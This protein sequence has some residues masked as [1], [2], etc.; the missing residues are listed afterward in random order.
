MAGGSSFL[1]SSSAAALLGSSGVAEDA[2]SA[3]AFLDSSGDA[4]DASPAATLLG[5]SGVAE[6]APSAATFLDSSGVAEG[7]FSSTGMAGVSSCLDSSAVTFSLGSSRAVEDL[8][9]STTAASLILDSL[10]VVADLSIEVVV[11]SDATGSDL[12]DCAG[13]ALRVDVGPEIALAVFAF[14]TT[15]ADLFFP[16]DSSS[17]VISLAGADSFFC[18]DFFSSFA[19]SSAEDF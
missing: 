3:A 12:F 10:A 17:F 9:S 19:G 5:S 2:S 4:E 8:S 6:D 16:T 13:A 18:P 11:G 7:V 15:G 14:F 1:D